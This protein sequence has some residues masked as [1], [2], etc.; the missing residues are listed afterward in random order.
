M[1]TDKTRGTFQDVIRGHSPTVTRL[2]RYLR[3]VIADASPDVVEVPRPK[4]NH[5]DYALGTTNP[6]EVFGYICPLGEYVRLGFFYGGALS[7]P[8]HLL[9]GSGKRLRHV[10]LYSLQDAERPAIRRLIEAAIAE[11]NQARS[12]GQSS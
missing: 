12:S 7:D 2:A 8:Q 5:A 3:Q 9:V 4:E 10:K 11:R 6:A 1:K